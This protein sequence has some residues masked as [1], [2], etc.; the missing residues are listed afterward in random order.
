MI[1]LGYKDTAE[2]VRTID[3]IVMD[4]RRA[5]PSVTYSRAKFI[6]EAVHRALAGIEVTPPRVR[7]RERVRS[8]AAA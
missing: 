5:D 6:K 2:I 8:S 1:A 7:I 4:R 3:D